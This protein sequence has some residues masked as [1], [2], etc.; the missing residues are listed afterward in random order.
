MMIRNRYM[1]FIVLAMLS[2]LHDGPVRHRRGS[3][4]EAA[5]R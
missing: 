2:R 1:V 5:D 4:T 3:R